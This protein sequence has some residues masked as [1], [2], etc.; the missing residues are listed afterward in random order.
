MISPEV[1]NA[2]LTCK[3]LVAM[4]EGGN[5]IRSTIINL[6]H[7]LP[8]FVLTSNALTGALHEQLFYLVEKKANARGRV[9]EVPFC[10]NGLL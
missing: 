2:D 3:Y 1:Q 4:V 6:C 5:E 8:L 9:G 7:E 10:F